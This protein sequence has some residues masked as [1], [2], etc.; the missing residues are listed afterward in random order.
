MPRE[1]IIE[2]HGDHDIRQ[3]EQQPDHRMFQREEHE[4]DDRAAK[5]PGQDETGIKNAADAPLNKRGDVDDADD[6]D[7]DEGLMLADQMA[8]RQRP[9]DNND[10]TKRQYRNQPEAKDDIVHCRPCHA[11][12]ATGYGHQKNGGF[13]Q[14]DLVGIV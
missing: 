1:K 6:L 8:K 12:Q 7:I 11:R 13:F 10:K 2:R 9:A 4:G 5:G 3:I 14:S